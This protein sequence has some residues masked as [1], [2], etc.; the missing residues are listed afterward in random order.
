LL[1]RYIIIYLLRKNIY[2]SQTHITLFARFFVLFSRDLTFLIGSLG[3]S[4]VLAYAAPSSPLAQPRNFIGG[5]LLSA[6]IGCLWRLSINHLDRATAAAF[7]VSTSI[8]AMQ[9]TE[10][11]H[12]PGG[13]IAL[14][15]VITEPTLPWANFLYIFIPVLS[16]SMIMLILALLIN[17]LSNYRTYP[18]RWW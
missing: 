16:A 11:V 7:A 9:F 6:L 4:A 8:A 14:I 1:L 12:P 5:N 18:V 15:A 13:A 10:T 2:Y 3:A 17:N